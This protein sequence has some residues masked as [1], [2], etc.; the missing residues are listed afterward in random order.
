MM[1]PNVYLTP[2]GEGHSKRGAHDAMKSL[3]S[4]RILWFWG[5][6]LW[7]NH[8]QATEFGLKTSVTYVMISSLGDII[9]T[10]LGDIWPTSGRS[11][12]WGGALSTTEDCHSYRLIE[13]PWS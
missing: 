11:Q 5:K 10:C 7:K 12:K 2:A 9:K 13:K 6:T 8:P 3:N 1:L 4:H